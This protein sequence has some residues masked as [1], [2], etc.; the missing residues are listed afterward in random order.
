VQPVLLACR[1]LQ[2]GDRR[3]VPVQELRRGRRL[4]H[5]VRDRRRVV[6][7]PHERDASR[8]PVPLLGVR[9]P[10]LPDGAQLP[11]LH[12]PPHAVQPATAL[13]RPALHLCVGERARN[14]EPGGLDESHRRRCTKARPALVS[15]TV[16]QAA[17]RGLA[18]DR[19]PPYPYRRLTRRRHRLCRLRRRAVQPLRRDRA[20]LHLS[21]VPVQDVR[22]GRGLR[23]TVPD[24]GRVVLLPDKRSHRVPDPLLGVQ[25]PTGLPEPELPLLR[26][27]ADAVQPAAVLGRPA[28]HVPGERPSGPE[29]LGGFGVKLLVAGV[30]WSFPRKDAGSPR[31][32]RYG[33]D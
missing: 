22:R 2:R 26:A 27:A 19:A 8:M 1:A 29:L 17:R 5:R 32:H 12:R 7:L 3:P 16:L 9:M 28:V 23:A 24:L 13:W 30:R 14:R 4:P 25:L 6:L 33:G 21:R 31:T 18:R 20:D 11:L 15:P 10:R